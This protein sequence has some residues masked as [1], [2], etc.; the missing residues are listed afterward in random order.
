[1]DRQE[2]RIWWNGELV[3]EADA[4]VPVT[5]LGWAG[6]EAVFEGMRGYHN[7]EQD[8]LYVFRL[9]EHIDRLM[10]SMRLVGMAPPWGRDELIA[11]CLHVLRANDCRQDVYLQV[12]AYVP[13]TGGGRFWTSAGCAVYMDWWPAPSRLGSGHTQTACVSSYRRIGEDVMP[14]RVKN[15]SN[16]RNGRLAAREAR[17]HGCDAAILLNAAGHVAEGPGACVVLVRDGIVVTP[18]LSSGILESITRDAILTLAREALGLEV[19]ERVVDRTELYLADEA[20]FVGNAA[21]AAPI[22][23]VDGHAV[24]A[25]TPGPISQRLAAL[26]HDVARGISPAYAHWRTPVALGALAGR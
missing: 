5:S 7:A 4:L 2:K 26:L 19:R 15:L 13:D 14:P 8:E 22:V 25:G 18:D 21:E 20:F 24:G 10:R 3:A 23:A 16:Y 9:E 6:V 11:G 17:R 12:L 1:M